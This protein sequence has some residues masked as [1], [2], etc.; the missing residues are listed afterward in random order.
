MHVYQRSVKGFNLFYDLEDFIVFYTIVSVL[1]KVYGVVLMEMCMMVDHVYLLMVA[2]SVDDLSSFVRHYT[3]VFV[4]ESNQDIGRKGPLFHKSFGSAPKKGSKKIRSAIVY[5]GNNPVEKKLCV[6]AEEYRWNFLAYLNDDFPFSKPIPYEKR[7]RSLRRATK[8]VN[9]MKAS[10]RY[11]TYAQVRRLLG[12]LSENERD[13]LTDYIITRYYSFDKQ[14]LLS[15]YDGVDELFHAMR[16]SAGSDF[17][18]KE[19]YY[20]GSDSL[21]MDMIDVVRRD[22]QIVPARSVVVLPLEQK[23]VVAQMLQ[24]KTN[25]SKIQ[26]GK[27]LHIEWADA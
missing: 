25:A 20:S 22:C 23:M 8:E 16:A 19:V 1:S 24:K 5:V 3:S 27:F 4:M 7:S 12:G 10:N 13:F 21:Y 11:L 17:D 26:L 6:R 18:I 14:I 9:N 15:F 2:E